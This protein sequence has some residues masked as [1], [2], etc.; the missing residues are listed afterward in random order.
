MNQAE[1]NDQPSHFKS[2][3]CG[4]IMQKHKKQ[5]RYGN[6]NETNYS[7]IGYKYTAMKQVPAS[8]IKTIRKALAGGWVTRASINSKVN[9]NRIHGMYPDISPRCL[10]EIVRA[11]FAEINLVENDAN[12]AGADC[13]RI[14][15][16]DRA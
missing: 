1:N 11:Y 14:L 13:S 3:T 7:K 15:M 16:E 12:L 6:S 9:V 8:T 5:K 2:G 10:Q 4:K